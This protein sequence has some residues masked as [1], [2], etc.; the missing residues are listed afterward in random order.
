MGTLICDERRR[1]TLPK[2]LAEEGDE[3]IAI[4]V[5]DEIILKPLIKD[6]IK[7]FEKLGE[8]LRGLSIGEI[9]KRAR[10]EAEKQAMERY[11]RRFKR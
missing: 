1:I 10:E 4:K 8:K 3:F 6:P 2:E 5:R 7:T 9:K 11:A